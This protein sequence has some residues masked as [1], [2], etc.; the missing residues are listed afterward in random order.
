[1]HRLHGS[2]GHGID[3]KI[4][5]KETKEV[6]AIEFELKKQYPGYKTKTVPHYYGC[7]GRVLKEYDKQPKELLGLRNQDELKKMQK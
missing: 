3:A 2:K 6:I 7:V 5:D 1:M 4:D